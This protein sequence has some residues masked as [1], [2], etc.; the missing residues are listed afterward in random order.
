MKKEAVC[1][2]SLFLSIGL[3]AL[4]DRSGRADTG[5]GAA[6][7]AGACI[8]LILVISLGDRAN[9][10]FRFAGSTGYAGITNHI[11]HSKF[12]PFEISFISWNQF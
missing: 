3:S 8:D 4:L 2:D 9:G 7:Y 1:C 6:V 11:C 12:P 10:T 5:T